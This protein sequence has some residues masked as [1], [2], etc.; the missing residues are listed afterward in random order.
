MLP[1]GWTNYSKEISGSDK[2]VFN[3]VIKKVAI[4]GYVGVG[5][6]PIGFQKQIVAG[7]NYCFFCIEETVSQDP[8]PICMTKIRASKDD[9][10]NVELK[11][12]DVVHPY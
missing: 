1:G 11:S 7:T 4:E 8:A 5:F 6:E 12:V 9:A 2:E 3:I 10:G